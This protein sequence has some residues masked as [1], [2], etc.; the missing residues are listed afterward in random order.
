M[1][2]TKDL[3]GTVD[4][5]LPFR[6]TARDYKL[7]TVKLLPPSAVYVSVLAD[8][9]VPALFTISS[10]DTLDCATLGTH[11]LD[12]ILKGRMVSNN[13]GLPITVALVGDATGAVSIDSIDNA[14]TIHF[15][16]GVST[17][18]LVE[19]AIT[20]ASNVVCP[21]IVKTPGTG[22]TVLQVGDAFART[23]VTAVVIL[24]QTSYPGQV[25]ATLTR[26]RTKLLLP[27]GDSDPYFW[28]ASLIDPDSQPY[29]IVA[30]SRLS[31][32]ATGT[33]LPT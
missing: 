17:V 33:I 8:M 26:D 12:S 22:A 23:L 7:Q 14:V 28:N 5:A 20:A 1:I 19:A 21:L 16:P 9:K 4:R 31:M 15:K 32:G 2:T 10:E 11:A 13:V 6:L 25:T 29:E 30:Q 3:R 27:T 24:D 18:T